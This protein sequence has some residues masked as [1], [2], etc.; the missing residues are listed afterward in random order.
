[1]RGVTMGLEAAGLGLLQYVNLTFSYRGPGKTWKG[2]KEERND[3]TEKRERV[4]MDN[5][6]RQ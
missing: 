1:M 3:K 4:K 5:I 6:E 2:R